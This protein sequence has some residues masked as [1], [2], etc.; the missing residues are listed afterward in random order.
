MF[1]ILECLQPG[2]V[3]WR[4]RPL[5]RAWKLHIDANIERYYRAY[6]HFLASE[7]NS[8]PQRPRH[9]PRERTRLPCEYYFRDRFEADSLYVEILQSNPAPGGFRS[10]AWS[11]FRLQIAQAQASDEAASYLSPDMNGVAVFRPVRGFNTIVEASSQVAIARIQ[12]FIFPGFKAANEEQMSDHLLQDGA[13]L[14]HE[15]GIF[16]VKYTL[17]SSRPDSTIKSLQIREISVPVRSLFL[18]ENPHVIVETD[19]VLERY[20]FYWLQPSSRLLDTKNLL[21]TYRHVRHKRQPRVIPL[22]AFFNPESSQRTTDKRPRYDRWKQFAKQICSCG[23]SLVCWWCDLL[24]CDICC[25]RQGYCASH[26]SEHRKFC[27]RAR[28][29]NM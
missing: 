14:T 5:S 1:L 3:W 2:T 23:S 19:I 9:Q 16:T 13:D 11:L 21:D 6:A 26:L 29:R 18:F 7:R 17:M 24:L 12:R 20:T 15:F 8:H 25:R 28:L 10:V 4:C 22:L 27:E